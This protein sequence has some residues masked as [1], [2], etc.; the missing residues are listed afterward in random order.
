MNQIQLTGLDCASCASKIQKHANKL[1]NVTKCQVNFATQKISYEL[2]SPDFDLAFKNELAL[3]L[4][5][6]EPDVQIIEETDKPQET[7]KTTLEWLNSQLI[8][9]IIAL[10]LITLQLFINPTYQ[11]PLLILAFIIIGYDIVLKALKNILQGA[12]FDE[13][14]LM[15]IATI[16]AFAIGQHTE[17]V[18]VMLFYQIGEYFQD[19]A[20]DHSRNS[21][22]ALLAIKATYANLK[23][24]EGIQQVAPETVQIDQQVLIKP[25]EKV[26]LDGIITEGKSFVDTAALTGESVPR[27]YQV[28]D[29][30]L[31]GSI[32]QSAVLTIRVTKAYADSTVAKILELVEN[33][34]EQKAPTENFITKFAKVYTP[35]VVLAAVLLA[36]LPPLIFGGGW[37]QWLYRALIFLVIS[38]PCALVISIPLGFFA[39]IGSASKNGI[40]I[41][42]SNYLEALNNVKT[43]VFDKT[44]TLTKGDFE[45]V[46]IHA[47]T[48]S[49]ESLLQLAA[50]LEQSSTHPIAQSILKKN[51][52]PLLTDLSNIQEIAGNGISADYQNKVLRAGK[53]SWLESLAIQT[54]TPK[55][56]GTAVHLSLETDYLGY[57]IIADQLKADAKMAIQQLNSDHMNTVM[58]TG[59]NQTI[60]NAIAEQLAIHE[61]HSD[62]LPQDKV[63]QISRLITDN[64]NEKVAFVGD[65]INDTPVLARA[66]IGFAMGALGSDAAVEAADVV[67][68]SDEPAKISTA[69]QIAKTTH[70]IVWQNIIFALGIKAIFLILGAFGIATMWEAVFADVGVTLIAVLN[71]LR[72][73]KIKKMQ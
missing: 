72:I 69:I 47:N 36:V 42:G 10:V 62:L 43:V 12:V 2:T 66:D 11:L 16:G 51:Q 40:L 34:S 23:T 35:I 57:I 1:P 20:V 73:L 67:L 48:Q 59:D 61:V 55:E 19:L 8:R 64:P 13:N 49:S 45:V 65:G 6:I 39:G 46:A 24:A 29:E 60:A 31:S 21:I 17:A 18:G 25:G 4:A 58:L 28:G 27:T 52:L 44:G 53:A 22:K 9:I 70:R 32:N 7:S 14:F 71:A 68:M 33:A 26:P 3:L 56:I 37:Y 50:S 41:K 38:C 30:L 5:D 63:D 15:S 54:T